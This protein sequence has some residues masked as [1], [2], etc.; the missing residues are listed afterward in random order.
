MPTEVVAARHLPELDRW[1]LTWGE[2]EHSPP[3]R[4]RSIPKFVAATFTEPVRIDWP[5]AIT[6]MRRDIAAADAAAAVAQAHA[7]QVRTRAAQQ[8][9]DSGIAASFGDAAAFLG[10]SRQRIHRL[11][12]DTGQ[13]PRP[14][15]LSRP[16]SRLGGDPR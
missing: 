10:L 5:A 3:M 7:Q 9:L 6:E 15:S 14:E 13:R 8:L 1:V 11:I 2:S 12:A 4:A 16:G